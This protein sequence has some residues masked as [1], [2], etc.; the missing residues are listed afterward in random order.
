MFS[1]NSLVV[2]PPTVL[3]EDQR[4]CFQAISLSARAIIKSLLYFKQIAD[5]LEYGSSLADDKYI[6]LYLNCWSAIDQTH[7]LCQL[8]QYLDNSLEGDHLPDEIMSFREKYAIATL[9]RNKM[10]HLRS[11]IPN[12]AAAK[13][14]NSTIFGSLSFY[15]CDGPDATE[16]SIFAIVFGALDKSYSFPVVNPAGRD[17][18]SGSSL[19][20][21]SSFDLRIGIH[22]LFNDVPRLARRLDEMM[23]R[24][25]E[26]WLQE[27]AEKGLGE[28]ALE[29]PAAGFVLSMKVTW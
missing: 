5:D 8:I 21:F 7:M 9:I 14:K 6:D 27:A 1:P 25:R 4:L 24:N 29:Q 15:R 11:N 23:E 12:L 28:E 10:D 17:V 26:N 20:E 16:G 2:R 22:E 3:R 18:W 19:F 13:K